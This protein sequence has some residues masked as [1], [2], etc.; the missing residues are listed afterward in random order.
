MNLTSQYLA[1]LPPTGSP[2][3][4]NDHRTADHRTADHRTAGNAPT[5]PAELRRS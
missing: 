1:T 3:A 2:A 4:G 5:L